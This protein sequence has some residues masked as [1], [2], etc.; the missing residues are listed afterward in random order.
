MKKII[1]LL[2]FLSFMDK[3][4]SLNFFPKVKLEFITTIWKKWKIER[5]KMETIK[6]INIQMKNIFGF[7]VQMK[8]Y[9]MGNHF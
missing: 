6:K 8:S 3:I 2:G 9:L 5:N 1:G 7:L 4:S